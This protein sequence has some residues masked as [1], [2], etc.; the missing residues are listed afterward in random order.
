MPASC[1][2]RKKT[3]DGGWKGIY[4]SL[5]GE[6]GSY[7]V[8]LNADGKEL[9]RTPLLT[10][11]RAVRADGRGALG[12]RRGSGT[13]LRSPRHHARGTTGGS[14]EAARACPRRG[15]R[16]A[17]GPPPPRGQGG[18]VEHARRDRRYRHGLDDPQW[19]PRRELGNQR[20]DDGLSGR[21]RFMLPGH[22]RGPVPGYRDSRI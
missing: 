5:S 20:P 13:G 9:N 22:G 17:G 8:T 11:D 15:P 19:T 21:S 18:R 6:G 7:D 3:S 1:C 14:V 16:V 12:Q 2:A 4:V 10:S